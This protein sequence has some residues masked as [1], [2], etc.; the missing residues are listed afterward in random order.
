MERLIAAGVNADSHDIT[1][2]FRSWAGRK[3][4]MVSDANYYDL[5]AEFI[6][7]EYNEQRKNSG[8]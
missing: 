8:R 6:N 3:N 1:A 2:E 5:W 7:E 4:F